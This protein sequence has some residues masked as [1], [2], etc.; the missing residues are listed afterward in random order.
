MPDGGR[1]GVRHPA[2]QVKHGVA[3]FSG[4]PA[5]VSRSDDKPEKTAEN[6]LWVGKLLVGIRNYSGN[7][8]GGVRLCKREQFSRHEDG[9]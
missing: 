4:N 7:S 8:C 5:F 1:G 9:V 3:V 2:R 6:F